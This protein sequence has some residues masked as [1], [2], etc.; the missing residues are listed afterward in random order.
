MSL[1]LLYIFLIS[2][3][4]PFQLMIG[5]HKKLR[6]IFRF[7]WDTILICKPHV[8]YWPWLFS[9]KFFTGTGQISFE[10]LYISFTFSSTIWSSSF[11]TPYFLM[12]GWRI[13]HANCISVDETLHVMYIAMACQCWEMS[14]LLKRDREYYVAS[15]SWIVLWVFYILYHSLRSLSDRQLGFL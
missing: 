6:L 14:I 4:K 12:L 13:A 11:K 3:L 8:S 9:Y 5:L 10:I 1:Y 15:Y 7:R 2:I